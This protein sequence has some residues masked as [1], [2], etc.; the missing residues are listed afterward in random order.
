M[1]SWEGRLV[2]ELRAFELENSSEMAHRTAD[3]EDFLNHR[4]DEG[5]ESNNEVY[6]RLTGYLKE[7]V[8]EKQL[9]GDRILV[10]THG[11]VLNSIMYTFNYTKGYRWKV[12]NCAWLKIRISENGNI[13]LVEY[14]NIEL[15]NSTN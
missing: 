4:W 6:E 7:I 15:E 1:G 9:Y 3:K 2:S 12:S 13:E 10:V 14:N 11:G 5:I 8:S